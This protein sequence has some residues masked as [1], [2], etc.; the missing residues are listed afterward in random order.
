MNFKKAFSAALLAGTM[1]AAG[2]AAAAFPDFTVDPDLNPVTLNS[3]TADKITGNYTEVLNLNP[4]GTFSFTLHWDA[5][6]FVA[7]D[8]T[9]PLTAAATGLGNSYLLYA[10]VTGSGTFVTVAGITTFTLIPGGTLDVFRSPDLAIGGDTQI[11]DGTGIEGSGTFNP[12]CSGG[13]NCGSFGQTTTFNLNA[14]GSTFFTFPIPFYNLSFQSGQFNLIDVTNFGDQTTN[15][16]LD[17]VFARVPEP[18]SIA[19]LGL[20]LL[21]VGFTQRRKA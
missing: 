1:L 21:G 16:S 15:G 17:V 12:T 19:L 9:S 7:N 5:G 8:G 2:S 14:A 18:T 20:A 10:D 3:F 11:A 4:D 13:I 6:Q